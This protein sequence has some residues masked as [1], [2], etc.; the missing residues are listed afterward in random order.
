MGFS[1]VGDGAA[2]LVARGPGFAFLGRGRPPRVIGPAGPV[3]A[4]LLQVAAA[5][6]AFLPYPEPQLVGLAGLADAHLPGAGDGPGRA[7]VGGHPPVAGAPGWPASAPVTRAPAS[8]GTVR[9]TG[10]K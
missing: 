8:S 9:A 4:V 1:S 7:R 2:A 10:S 5:G 3:R 6:A